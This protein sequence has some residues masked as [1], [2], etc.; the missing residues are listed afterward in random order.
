MCG[1]K[2]NLDSVKEIEVLNHQK[3]LE[4]GAKNPYVTFERDEKTKEIKPETIKVKDTVE[5]GTKTY[6]AYKA[7]EGTYGK[8]EITYRPS[9][10]KD[11]ANGVISI[12]CL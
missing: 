8:V 4:D 10:C 7:T 12:R 11:Q 6:D 3:L 5:E 9:V 2:K 1:A